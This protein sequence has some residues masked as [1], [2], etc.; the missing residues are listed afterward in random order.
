MTESRTDRERHGEFECIA[1][2]A[3]VFSFVETRD[4]P[5]GWRWHPDRNGWT[6]EECSKDD[7]V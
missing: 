4:P 7:E 6:C 2:D 3:T 1:C 5:S